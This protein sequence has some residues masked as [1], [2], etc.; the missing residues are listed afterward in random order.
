MECSQHDDRC[1]P[2][3]LSPP[4]RPS[5]IATARRRATNPGIHQRS[6]HSQPATRENHDD[7]TDWQRTHQQPVQAFPKHLPDWRFINYL[8]TYLLTYL[9]SHSTHNRAV[10]GN[11]LT[12]VKKTK[13]KKHA[14]KETKP[15]PICS[16][17][18]VRTAHTSVHITEYT[19]QHRIV[20][21]SFPLILQKS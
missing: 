8:L 17:S 15:K 1:I 19:I 14:Q 18:P 21:I 12:L 10:R 11:K 16:S 6:R 4:R 2:V 7:C 9:K 20:L 13:I 5:P 3:P